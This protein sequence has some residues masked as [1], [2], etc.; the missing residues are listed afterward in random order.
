[1]GRAS[2][3][4]FAWAFAALVSQPLA[5]TASK[6][7][8]IDEIVDFPAPGQVCSQ[9]DLNTVTASLQTAM[10]ADAWSGNRK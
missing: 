9:G 8:F 5:A 7:Y 1:M 3:L 2:K 4:H 6:T 10:T